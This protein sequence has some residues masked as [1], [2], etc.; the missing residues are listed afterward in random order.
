MNFW[1]RVM[2]IAMLLG[3]LLAIFA[4]MWADPW[5]L[6]PNPWTPTPHPTI[7]D[8]QLPTL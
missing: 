2:L 8:Q 4:W 3:L 6:G 1:I 7:T 5:P